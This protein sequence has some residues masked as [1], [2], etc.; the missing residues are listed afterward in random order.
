M[1]LIIAGGRNFKPEPKHWEWLDE[2]RYMLDNSGSRITYVVSGAARGADAFG[3]KWATHNSIMVKRFPAKWKEYGKRAGALRNYIMAHWAARDD[4]AVVLF[5]G[6][7]GT[8]L[9]KEMAERM[10]LRIY[11]WRDREE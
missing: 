4:G 7:A 5:P 11:D 2:L 10:E 9:M 3:E 8:A 1:R 6:G